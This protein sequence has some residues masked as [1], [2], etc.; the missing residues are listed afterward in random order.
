MGTLQAER[1]AQAKAQAEAKARAA[2][3]AAAGARGSGAGGVEG[4]SE[5][6]SSMDGAKAQRDTAAGGDL[7]QRVLLRKLDTMAVLVVAGIASVDAAVSPAEAKEQDELTA[8]VVTSVRRKGGEGCWHYITHVL[9][10]RNT[11]PHDL[12]FRFVFL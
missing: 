4:G 2:P 6:G 8:Q 12:F 7:K 5:G 11:R 1:A 9:R 10:S 3:G